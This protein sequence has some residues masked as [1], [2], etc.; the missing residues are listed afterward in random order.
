MAGDIEVDVT[1]VK[2]LEAAA[3]GVANALGGLES[4]VVAAGDLPDG[5]FG[6]LPFASDMLRAK[7]A[8]QVADGTTLFR[9][10]QDA[11]T[12]VGAALGS[13][14]EAYERNE[15]DIDS[16]FRAMREGMGR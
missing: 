16:G 2:R 1:A 14:A 6:H 5:A 3:T 7:Y 13:T 4:R 11:F 15:Q 12:R 8:E 9:A 10:G